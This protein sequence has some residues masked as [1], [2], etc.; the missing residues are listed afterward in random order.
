ME[1]AL[2]INGALSSA[3]P[4]LRDLKWLLEYGDL[5]RLELLELGHPVEGSEC[6]SRPLCQPWRRI[7]GTGSVVALVLSGRRCG[8]CVEER[9]ISSLAIVDVSRPWPFDVVV[10]VVKRRR[11]CVTRMTSSR[12]VYVNP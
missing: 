11:Y 7:A 12:G 2:V 1:C 5:L 3:A 10:V 8:V 4:L 9:F 6:D